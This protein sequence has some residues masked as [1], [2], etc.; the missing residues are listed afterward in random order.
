MGDFVKKHQLLALRLGNPSQNE[1][2][3][4]LVNHGLSLNAKKLKKLR[5]RKEIYGYFSFYSFDVL[6]VTFL[7]K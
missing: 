7:K 4:Q 1:Q 3:Q 6:R 2:T 5:L